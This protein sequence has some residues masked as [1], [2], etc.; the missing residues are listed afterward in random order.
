MHEGLYLLDRDR[1]IIYWNKGAEEITGFSSSEAVGCFCRDNVLNHVNEAGIPLCSSALCPALNSMITGSS[2][3]E[4]LYLRHKE[5]HR[6][7]L[8]T[9]VTP[10]K[11][12]DGKIVGAM[13]LFT[14]D[15]ATVESRRKIIE[16]EKMALLDVL[17]QLGNRRHLEM[18]IQSCLAEMRRYGWPF[19]ILF[20]DVDGFKRIND[21]YGHEVGDRTLKIVAATMSNSLRSSDFLGRWG[22]DEFLAIVLNAAGDQLPGLGNKLRALVEQSTINA[23]RT[24]ERVTISVGATSAEIDDTMHILL[25]RA[26]TLMYR[27]KASGG[28]LVTIGYS[29]SK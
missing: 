15:Q 19:G 20:M 24:L 11:D 16:L 27:S 23:G 18:H 29:E 28:N 21:L 26:D 17:T 7:A 4:T 14:T 25:E 6:V 12:A 8:L 13:E 3:E 5:G 10:I 22:G 1:R 2:A 9:R